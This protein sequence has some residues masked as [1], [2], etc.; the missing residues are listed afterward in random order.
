[1]NRG[2]IWW[3]DLH[4]KPRPVVLVSRGSHLLAR[5]S[6]M[7]APLTRRGRGLLTEVR[8]GRGDGLRLPC[9][10]DAATLHTIDKSRLLRRVAALSSSSLAALDDALRFALGHD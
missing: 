3:A 6:V 5:D 10:A 2:E 9:V 8:L 7:V 1:M 4:P